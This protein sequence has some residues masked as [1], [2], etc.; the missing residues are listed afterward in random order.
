MNLL[1]LLNGD[2]GQNAVLVQ[3]M[4]I[5]MSFSSRV[6]NKN[7]QSLCDCLDKQKIRPWC[8][9]VFAKSEDYIQLKFSLLS[10]FCQGF[11]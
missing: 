2:T 3:I 4:V 7:F 5:S 11:G 8:L 10:Q 9:R 1:I 6:T